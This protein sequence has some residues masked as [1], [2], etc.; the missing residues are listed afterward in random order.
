MIRL[1]STHLPLAASI[2]FCASA[3]LIGAVDA[4]EVVRHWLIAVLFLVVGLFGALVVLYVFTIRPMQSDLESEVHQRTDAESRRQAA[5]QRAARAVL[6]C[7]I[8]ID[9]VRR[10]KEELQ[11]K[12]ACVDEIC[13]EVHTLR[14]QLDQRLRE[15]APKA[16]PKRGGGERGGPPQV[17]RWPSVFK[18]LLVSTTW[19]SV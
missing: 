6:A 12:T 19:V 10:Q 15:T 7:D 17:V 3:I 18:S 5:E 8:E 11:R 1:S 2:L 16:K 13:V 4:D 9:K 14:L